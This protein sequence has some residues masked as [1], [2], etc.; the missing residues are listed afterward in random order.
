MQT[1]FTIRLLAL[2]VTG[3]NERAIRK[4]LHEVDPAV[5]PLGDDLDELVARNVIIDLAT[6][7][8]FTREGRLLAKLLEETLD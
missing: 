5:D 7:R 6:M 8:A 3:G 2:R 4:L 1:R